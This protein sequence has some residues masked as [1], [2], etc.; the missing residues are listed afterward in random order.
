MAHRPTQRRAIAGFLLAM[1]GVL[2]AAACLV[3]TTET[4]PRSDLAADAL[5]GLGASRDEIATP[6]RVPVS[7]VPDRG[8]VP[9]GAPVHP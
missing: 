7:P 1:L 5:G 8:A 6:S 2:F 9:P 4:A 3:P